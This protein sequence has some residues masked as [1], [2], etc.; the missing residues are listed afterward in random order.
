MYTLALNFVLPALPFLVV[1][2]TT[3][4]DAFEPYMAAEAASFR[5]SMVSIS[6]GFKKASGLFCV[7]FPSERVLI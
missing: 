4:L 3:P 7:K 6:S 5:I 1:M 2:M